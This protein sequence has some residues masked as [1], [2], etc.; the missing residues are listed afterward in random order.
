MDNKH[1]IVGLNNR[2]ILDFAYDNIE[3]RFNKQYFIYSQNKNKGVFRNDKF[4]IEPIVNISENL[5]S[6]IWFQDYW[7]L[8]ILDENQ[9]IKGYISEKGVFFYTN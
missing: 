2:Q 9:K 4:K 5:G 8:E 6:V 1:G 7:F 3:Y